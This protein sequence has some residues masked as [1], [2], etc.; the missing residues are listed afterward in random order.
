MKAKTKFLQ[1]YRQLPKE[2]T[3]NL[4]LDFKGF[5]YSLKV[6][7][8]EVRDNTTLGNMFLNELGYKDE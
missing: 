4:V 5:P 6:I 8:L 7:C 1:M 2:S 3:N